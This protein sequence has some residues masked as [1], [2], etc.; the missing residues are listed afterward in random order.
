MRRRQFLQ[1]TGV[2]IAAGY[3]PN[4]LSQSAQAQSREETLRVL[5]PAILNTYDPS[6]NGGNRP[7]WNLGWNVY[8]RLL[9]YGR[10]EVSPGVFYYNYY[11]IKGEV[12]ES[13][14]E[15]SDGRSITFKL[16]PNAVFHDGSPITASD[17]KWSLDRAVSITVPKNQLSTGSLTKPEQFVVLDERTIRIDFPRKDRFALPN[18]ALV[19]PAIFNARLAKPHATNDDPWATDWLKT[20]TAG[21]GAYQVESYTPGQQVTFTRFDKWAAGP[22]PYFKRIIYQVVPAAS[23]RQAALERGDADIALTLEPKDLEGLEKKSG[24]KV[25]S[26][27]MRN[28]FQVIGLNSLI[29]PLDRVKVR[30]AIAA[31]LPYKDMFTAAIFGRGRPLFGGTDWHPKPEDWPAPQPYTTDY[32][33]AKKLLA[34]AGMPNGF[35]TTFSYDIG[36]ETIAG[37]IAALLQESLRR[38]GI[39]VTINKVPSAQIA[40]LLTE[41]KL[42]M[43]FENGSAWLNDPDYFF[44][45]FY[46]LDHR[47]NYGSFKDPEMDRLVETARW[48]TDKAKYDAEIEAMIGMVYERVP[49][50]MLWQPALD[51]P[52]RSDISGYTYWVHQQLDYRFMKRA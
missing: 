16:R 38:V 4:S 40:T 47:W 37:P 51:T 41:K 27:P 45:I 20:N 29:A 21:S 3:L 10:R 39:K 5:A 8:D 44:R 50:V 1:G 15:S 17:V 19:F 31:A 42:A 34:E 2:A 35:D 25:I 22:L 49:M 24:V 36:V 43:F 12:A 7:S 52:M 23:S 9:T 13:W 48:E 33:R 14:V 32:E 18:L 26:I 46:H 30:Q 11:D 28:A 6:G